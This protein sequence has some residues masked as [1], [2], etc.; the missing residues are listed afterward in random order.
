VGNLLLA[1]VA[2]LVILYF[3]NQRSLGEFRANAGRNLVLGL[4]AAFALGLVIN[5]IRGLL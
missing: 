3:V 1:P 5:G 2:V 4:T